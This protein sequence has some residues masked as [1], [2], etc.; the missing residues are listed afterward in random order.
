[1]QQAVTEPRWRLDASQHHVGG[2]VLMENRFGADI[3]V[4]LGR[5][6][7]AVEMVGPFDSRMG[8][9]G[10]VLRHDN[11]LLEGAFDPRSDGS[12]AGF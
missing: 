12:V 5:L 6:G 11:G 10:A 2:K 1:L 3:E 9:A 7:H 4:G 8:H